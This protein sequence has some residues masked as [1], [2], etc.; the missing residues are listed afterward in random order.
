[1]SLQT[2]NST[3]ATTV[4]VTAPAGLP[5][6]SLFLM[7]ASLNCETKLK[8]VEPDMQALEKNFQLPLKNMQGFSTSKSRNFITDL[9]SSSLASMVA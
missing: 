4:G 3:F 9:C 5:G 1:M 8:K 7:L 6:L 2:K